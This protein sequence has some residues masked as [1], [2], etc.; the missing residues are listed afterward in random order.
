MRDL[1]RRVLLAWLVAS[2]GLLLLYGGAVLHQGAAGFYRLQGPAD[3]TSVELKFAATAL[4]WVGFGALIALSQFPGF[5]RR[6]AALL[7]V[8]AVLGFSFLDFVRGPNGILV[9][10]FSNY[11][12]AARDMYHGRPIDQ[13]PLRLYL[14]PPLLATTLMPLVPYGLSLAS[15]LF[16]ILN[17][18]AAVLL[19]PLL[20]AA[21]GRYRFPPLL[22]AAVTLLLLAVNV[23]L[24]DTL[25]Y[26]QIN[27]FVVD[28]TLG[29][30]LLYPRACWASALALALAVHLKVYPV[31]LVL[32]FLVARDWR[33]VGWFALWAVAVVVGTSLINGPAYYLDFLHQAASLR[34]PGI[35]N[36]AVDSLVH[37]TLRLL[38]P[39]WLGLDRPLALGLRGLLA[40]AVAWP[41]WRLLRR[42]ALGSGS[43]AERITLTGQVVLPPL[44]LAVS[45]SLWPHH[46]VLLSLTLAVLPALLRTPIQ[47]WLYLAATVAV[48]CLPVNEVYPLS[49]LRLL[50]LVLL[51]WLLATLEPGEP[52][53]DGPW[54]SR[55]RSRV[56]SFG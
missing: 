20:Y 51:A 27:L 35:R 11:F 23:P 3:A 39:G 21:L 54:F 9:G 40:L 56:E 18:G 47:W 50:A 13:Q 37:N 48:I 46:F 22:A 43:R 41:A 32:A 49:Y 16:R 2:A 30:L 52:M 36:V 5:V 15:N 44:M 24:L 10:D 1:G 31:L 34:E 14:Y 28:L 12:L 25:R 29:C 42:G 55:W 38:L 33:W 6:H 45:P 26:Q 19:V 53:P 4:A 17:L 8:L 7:V